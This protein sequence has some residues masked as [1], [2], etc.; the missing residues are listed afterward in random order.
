MRTFN[1]HVVICILSHLSLQ[2][3]VKNFFFCKHLKQT[4]FKEALSLTNLT[5]VSRFKIPPESKQ[6]NSQRNSSQVC[7]PKDFPLVERTIVDHCQPPS[8]SQRHAHL[9]LWLQKLK[10]YF[11][12]CNWIETT[13]IE[14]GKLKFKWF[15]VSFLLHPLLPNQWIT[16]RTCWVLRPEQSWMYTL[17]F[18]GHLYV[19]ECHTTVRTDV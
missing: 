11:K 3:R 10:L 16:A 7:A 6:M 17:C 5:F 4:K 18:H 1:I 9:Q 8:T 15:S 19:V 13:A 2:P 12:H 14:G